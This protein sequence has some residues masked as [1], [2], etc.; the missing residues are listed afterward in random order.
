MLIGGTGLKS[1]SDGQMGAAAG[2]STWEQCEKMDQEVYSDWRG[3]KQF[4][5]PRSTLGGCPW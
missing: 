3:R 1:G 4:A 2:S 5:R